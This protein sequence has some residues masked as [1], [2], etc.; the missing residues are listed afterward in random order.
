MDS[1]IGMLVFCGGGFAGA[2][3]LLPARGVKGWAYETWWMFYCVVGLLLMPALVCAIAVPDFC[4]V[5]ASASGSR[6]AATLS[7][8][9]SSPSRTTGTEASR[10]E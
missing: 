6:S 5:V 2:T 10:K 7:R 8:S 9:A 3:F 1:V 4:G